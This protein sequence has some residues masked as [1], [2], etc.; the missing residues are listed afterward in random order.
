LRQA[1]ASTDH[2]GDLNIPAVSFRSQVRYAEAEPLFRQALDIMER[3]KGAEH[4]DVA[5]ILNNL[6]ELYYIQGRYVQAEPLY[7][8]ALAIKEKVLGPDALAL[9]TTLETYSALLART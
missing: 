5:I 2:A 3:A 4:L 8:R 9:A 7:Q 6:G 1:R